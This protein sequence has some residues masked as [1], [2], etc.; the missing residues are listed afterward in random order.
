MK[1]EKQ[2]AK[3]D[4][5]AIDEMA[6]K[7]MDVKMS[8]NLIK[9]DK[10]KY[11]GEI[12]FGVDHETFGQIINQMVTGITSHYAVVYVINKEQFD[13]IKNAK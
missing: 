4:M 5:Q 9:A 2:A 11:G 1:I 10:R 12:T 6:S 3:T 8:G 13:K 7:N